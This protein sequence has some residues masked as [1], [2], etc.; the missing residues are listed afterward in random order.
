MTLR[1][2]LGEKVVPTMETAMLMAM[3]MGMTIVMARLFASDQR[4]ER[5]VVSLGCSLGIMALG[6]W[7][8]KAKLL[9][10]FWPLIN[11]VHGQRRVPFLHGQRRVPLCVASPP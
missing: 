2:V 9:F 1:S 10:S 6:L 7:L 3:A 4:S 5:A 8:H 11:F